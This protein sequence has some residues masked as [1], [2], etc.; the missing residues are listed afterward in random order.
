MKTICSAL[1]LL[2]LIAVTSPSASAQY[3]RYSNYYSPYGYSASYYRPYGGYRNSG[4]YY[5]GA[6]SGY[7]YGGG[8]LIQ[9]LDSQGRAGHA[10]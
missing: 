8:N 7:G 5:Y 10:R 4:A 6:Y 3:Y 2:S 1:L 9:R